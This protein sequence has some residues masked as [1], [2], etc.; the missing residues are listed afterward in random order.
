MN[1]FIMVFDTETS[2]LPTR[3]NNKFPLF[4]NLEAYNQARLVQFSCIIYN[5]TENKKMEEIDFIIKPEG[6]VINNSHIH[7][8]TNEIALNKGILINDLF[9]KLDKLMEN[10]DINLIVGHNVIF[11][12]NIMK[13]EIFR[14]MK[15]NMLVNFNLMKL[16]NKKYF[17]TMKNS[18]NI[19]KIPNTNYP[20]KFKYPKLEELYFHLYGKK[21]ENLH[22]SLN[23]TRYTLDC[24]I[25]I[26]KI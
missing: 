19:C 25:K 11:D 6:F 9:I 23:D 24:F 18:I 13:S 16:F 22:N 8:I 1:N 2:G 4:N 20:G 7:N 12:I 15:K 3:I 21:P 10:F 14:F 17:C 26:F 5:L